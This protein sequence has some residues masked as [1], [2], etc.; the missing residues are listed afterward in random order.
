MEGRIESLEKD[1]SELTT[2][3]QD[4]VMAVDHARLGPLIDQ[5]ALLQAELDACMERWEALQELLAEGDL[6]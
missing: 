3:M 5:H 4:P 6:S 1:L 2:E